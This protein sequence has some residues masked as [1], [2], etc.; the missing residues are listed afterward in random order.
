MKVTVKTKGTNNDDWTEHEIDVES[1]NTAQAEADAIFGVKRN[2]KGE[3]T[4]ADMIQVEI[5]SPN[6]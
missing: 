3:Q 4:N 6:K 1:L 2:K 5:I